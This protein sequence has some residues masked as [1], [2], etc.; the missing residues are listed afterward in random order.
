MS[1]V[2]ALAPLGKVAGSKKKWLAEVVA[3]TLAGS[4]TSAFVGALLGVLGKQLLIMRFGKQAIL[5]ALAIG[6]IAIA[7]ELGW[8]TF[9]LP[10][11]RRQTKDVWGKLLPGMMAAV[12]W[13]LDLGLIF[14]TRLTFSGIWLLA[15]VAI[16]VGE[17]TYGA[18]LFILYWL[19]RAL[20]VW[21]VPFL[22]PNANA[23]P[24][25]LDGIYVHY[26]LF[27]R[28]HVLGLIWSVFVLIVWL[29]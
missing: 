22:M 26:R 28:I 25:V 19:G 14:T 5:V 9:P 11:L 18:M 16:L 20:S 29:I 1:L 2:G 13:G 15:V 10:Q 23:T 3:Y 7:R 17:P 12:L 4:V 6:L 21:I 8:L 27:Q 24:W